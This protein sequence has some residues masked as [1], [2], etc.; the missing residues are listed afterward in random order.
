[1][2]RRQQEQ[3]AD[4]GRAF[5][6]SLEEIIDMGEDEIRTGSDYLRNDREE[7][8]VRR[9]EEYE[10]PIPIEEE[11]EQPMPMPVDMND[12]LAQYDVNIK[13]VHNGFIVGVGCQT[14]V[15][16]SFD[17]LSKYMAI[18]YDDPRGTYEKHYK[19][20]LLK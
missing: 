14:F 15:F 16:E 8:L 4:L 5:Q 20:E 3:I 12:K 2:N 9:E 17:K 11:Y 6:S 19:G 1:M 13:H 7:T 18:Y 10:Q